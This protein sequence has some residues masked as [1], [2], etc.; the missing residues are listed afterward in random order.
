MKVFMVNYIFVYNYGLSHL[1]PLKKM[2][3]WKIQEKKQLYI[4]LM[5]HFLGLLVILTLLNYSLQDI[6][7]Y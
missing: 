6:G 1:I 4:E 2:Q 3:L 5:E 7:N